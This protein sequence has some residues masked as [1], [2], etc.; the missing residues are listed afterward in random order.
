MQSFVLLLVLLLMDFGGGL[1][2]WKAA[3]A[4]D[5]RT[6]AISFGAAGVCS[7]SPLCSKPGNPS[8]LLLKYCNPVSSYLY[9]FFVRRMRGS[10]KG[11]GYATPPSSSELPFTHDAAA[12][13]HALRELRELLSSRLYGQPHVVDALIEVVRYKIYHPLE[14][15]VVHLAGDNGVGKTF[16]ARLVSRALSLRCGG[17]SPGCEAGDNLLTI[18]GTSFEGLPL[19]EAR[20]DVVGRLSRHLRAFPHGLVLID[21]LTAMD[22]ALV[23]ALA[24]LFG[25]GTH[26]PEQLYPAYPDDPTPPA[27]PTTASKG[28]AVSASAAV[29]AASAPPVSQLLVF[30]TTDLGKQGRTRGRSLREIETMVRGAFTELYGALL[31]AYTH[32]FAYLPFSAGTA[33]AVVRGAVAQLPCELFDGGGGAT[34]S[35]PVIA[36]DIDEAA[37]AFLVQQLRPE[38]DGRENAHAL[39]RATNR[40]RTQVLAYLETHGMDSRVVVRLVLD[41][42]A[43]EVRLRVEGGKGKGADL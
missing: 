35:P 17:N 24:P 21:D 4:G 36:S 26:F 12:R 31:P 40:L 5:S 37:V 11:E 25:R 28:K 1:G 3:A 29:A 30:I 34:A 38:W 8:E 10:R 39:K 42:R 22:P 20:R 14:P 6:P 32:T 27:G 9:R 43:M 23:A 15:T 41:E 7:R 2:A 18:S 16:T 13:A 33:E 19:E